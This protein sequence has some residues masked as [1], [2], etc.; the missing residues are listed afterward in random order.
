MKYV[1]QFKNKEDSNWMN[2]WSNDHN[3]PSLEEL[4]ILKK[5]HNQA[6]SD[7]DF[8]IMNLETNKEA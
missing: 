4:Q 7:K 1:Y 3:Y 2:F 6:N 8:R 5:K